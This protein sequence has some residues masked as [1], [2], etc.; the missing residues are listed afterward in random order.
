MKAHPIFAAFTFSQLCLLSSARAG[1]SYRELKKDD[2]IIGGTAATQGQYSFA[3]ALQ[4]RLGLFC[5]GSL[6]AKD[7]ILTAAHCQGPPF[8]VVV[9]RRNLSKNDG[10]VIPIKKQLPHPRYNDRRTDNDFMLVFLKRAVTAKNVDL[11]KLNSQSSV[12][13]VGARVTAMGWGDTDSRDNVSRLSNVLMKVQVNVLSNDECEDSSDRYQS[14]YGSITKNMLC[15]KAN[16]KDSCQGDSGGPL[17]LKR[18]GQDVQ[19]GIVSWGIDCASQYFPGVYARVSSAYE[20]IENEV[21]KGSDYA[22]EAGFNCRTNASSK[23]LNPAPAPTPSGGGG[24]SN[25]NGINGGRVDD[26]WNDDRWDDNDDWW[27]YILDLI[28]WGNN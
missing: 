18:G 25:D 20:W 6:I 9:G 28:G 16:R 8:D 10:Q 12:P 21:C 3:V 5:G 11:V 1:S 23:P 17:V 13:S 7:V 2:R 19:V 26:D 27:N 14:Y 24:G 22:S 4:D 15:A